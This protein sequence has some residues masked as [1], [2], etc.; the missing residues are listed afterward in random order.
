MN[1][2]TW[3]TVI[4]FAIACNAG[5]AQAQIN[6]YGYTAG[7]NVSDFMT[8]DMRFSPLWQSYQA[9]QRAVNTPLPQPMPSRSTAPAALP[10]SA[11]V[12]ATPLPKQTDYALRFFGGESAR[13]TLQQMPQ[14]ASSGSSVPVPAVARAQKP[15]RSV[16]RGHT[17]SP[18]LNLDRPETSEELPNYFTYVRPQFEQNDVNRRQQHE[19]NNLQRQV[20]TVSYTS[21]ASN[22]AG[23]PATGHSSRF[24]DTGRFYGGWKR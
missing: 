23:T 4:A 24:N 11:I 10:P 19:M 7:T 16:S 2:P 18:W 21:S 22:R 6:E 9:N 14:R 15:Y 20:Q 5:V 17:I 1:R 8:H 13:Q 12:G 3:S